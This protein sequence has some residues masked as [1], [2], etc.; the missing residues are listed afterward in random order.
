MFSGRCVVTSEQEYRGFLSSLQDEQ[1]VGVQKFH[2]KRTGRLDYSH[3]YWALI[4]GSI[5]GGQVCY[6]E[7]CD[8]ARASFNNDGC[9]VYPCSNDPLGSIFPDRLIPWN[10]EL[11]FL[12]KPSI[13][14][15]RPIW[16]PLWDHQYFFLDKHG[17]SHGCVRKFLQELKRDGTEIATHS[18]FASEGTLIQVFGGS[19]LDLDAVPGYLYSERLLS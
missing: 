7:D 10:S 12:A 17:P 5:S 9:L 18:W 11:E 3:Q 8:Y 19:Y 16:E 1:T 13:R 2:G 4:E 14:S 15:D 6:R